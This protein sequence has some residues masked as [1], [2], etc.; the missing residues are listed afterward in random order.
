VLDLLTGLVDKSLVTTNDQ[1][2]QTRYRLL[3][4]VRQ[5]AT[6]RLADADER[7]AVR[8]RHLDYYLALAETAELQQVLGAG[9]DDPVLQTLTTELP[10][11]RT[12]LQWAATTAPAPGYAW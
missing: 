10:N 1:G 8:D 9:D 2:P 12:A 3:E 7:D 5:Y 6:V 4:T 11:L